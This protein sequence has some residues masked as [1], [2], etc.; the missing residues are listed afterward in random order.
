MYGLKCV[1]YFET[2]SSAHRRPTR[3]AALQKVGS[4]RWSSEQPDAIAHPDT[5]ADSRASYYLVLPH[6]TMRMDSHGRATRLKAES[7]L[8][9]ALRILSIAESLYPGGSSC[10]CTSKTI[11]PTR[12]RAPSFIRLS[13]RPQPFRRLAAGSVAPPPSQSA[14]GRT[15]CLLHGPAVVAGV[16]RSRPLHRIPR[17]LRVARRAWHRRTAFAA[18]VVEHGSAHSA[19]NS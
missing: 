1:E 7:S 2:S 14:R 5:I 6:Y 8:C 16:M 9:A 13:R 11:E 17:F 18:L 10:I 15:E 19:S 12:P 4:S 3:V